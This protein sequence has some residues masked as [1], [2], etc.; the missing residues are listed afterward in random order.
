MTNENKELSEIH[1]R[2]ELPSMERAVS[3]TLDEYL[4][5]LHGIM[6]SW[7]YPIEF[8]EFLG[9]R[10]YIIKKK[11]KPP[12]E[13]TLFKVRLLQSTFGNS[14]GDILNIKMVDENDDLYYYDGFRRWSVLEKIEEGT[15]WE[16]TNKK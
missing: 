12:R 16:R 11:S 15:W 1:K 13:P 9:E 5:R 4:S 8:I 3:D 6:S 14:E 7:A 10:G 2:N